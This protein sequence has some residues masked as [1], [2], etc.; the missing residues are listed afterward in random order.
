MGNLFGTDGIRGVANEKVTA[1]MAYNLG[2]AL[3]IHLLRTAK[4]KVVLVGR[5]TRVSG[6]M[7]FSAL[8][9][10][11]NEMGFSVLTTGVLPTPALSY[12]TR[13]LEVDAG[14]MITASHNP[15]THNGVKLYDS[16]GR[17]MPQDM[18]AEIEKIYADIES[19]RGVEPE[20]IGGVEQNDDLL[21][22]WVDYIIEALKMPK[23]N[24]L[25][26]A[27]DTANGAGSAVIPFVF[28]LLGARGM[29]FNNSLDG[30]LINRDCGSVHAEKFASVVVNAGA[31]YGFSFDGDADRVLVINR[32]GRI[33][34][35]SDMMYIFARYLHEKGELHGD[36]LVSTTITNCGLES[37]L[38]SFGIKMVRTNVGG[39]FIENEMLA[40]NYNLG[41]EENGHIMYSD[42][43]GESCGLTAALL[44]LKIVIEKKKSAVD[45]LEGLK[46]TK[47]ATADVIVSE[48]QK[49]EIEK[50]ALDDFVNELEDTL[51]SAGRII[52]RPSG[53]ERVIRVL[54]E[55]ENESVL[56]L[57]R[58][59]IAREIE[60]I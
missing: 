48:R 18:Q 9:A 6:E 27:L 52:V 50:G 47:I 8:S 1:L 34:D 24:G 51:G 59:K 16:D 29:A 44:L 19:Y 58:D 20:N 39:L 12:L 13:T 5:D 2:K 17:K 42:V 3:A 21:R 31:D 43:N 25:K 14:V 37:S 11:L 55:G 4:Y 35:G 22:L 10:G 38:N 7:I 46:R 30:S 56:N 40:K 36:T 15:A 60:K 54:V 57:L 53:T 28:K 32:D 26:I 45:L 23:L 49:V 41:G 33:L